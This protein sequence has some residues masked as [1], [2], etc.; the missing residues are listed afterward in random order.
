LFPSV[1]FKSAKLRSFL[2]FN[3]KSPKRKKDTPENSVVSFCCAN[4][5]ASFVTFVLKKPNPI[6]SAI[7]ELDHNPRNLKESSTRFPYMIY[8]LSVLV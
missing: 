7:P 3:P 5:S 6:P 4:K 1:K 2:K 8:S